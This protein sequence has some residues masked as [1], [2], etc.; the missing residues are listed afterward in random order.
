MRRLSLLAGA[1]ALALAGLASAQAVF[2]DN[3]RVHTAGPA[4]TL[5]NGDVLITDGLITAVGRE[6]APPPGALRIDA[7][8]QP[9]TPGLFAG[10]TALPESDATRRFTSGLPGVSHH[11]LGAGP[12]RS[13]SS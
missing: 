5:E 6:L 3:A 9:L 13:T 8:G 12:L 4:G 10:L 1:L 2:I 7:K 11:K